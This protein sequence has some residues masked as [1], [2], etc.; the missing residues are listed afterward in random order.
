MHKQRY[1]RDLHDAQHLQIAQRRGVHA[2]CS[3]CQHVRILLSTLAVDFGCCLQEREA[4]LIK[5]EAA[6][7]AAQQEQQ[8]ARMAA[9]VELARLESSSR[10]LGKQLREAEA[11]YITGSE[12]LAEL[13]REVSARCCC[14]MCMD[15]TE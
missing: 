6:L 4:S 11:D 10:Q 15:V 14:G 3:A 5:R 8:E 9:Q 12:R 1:C 13:Q 7:S 2:C